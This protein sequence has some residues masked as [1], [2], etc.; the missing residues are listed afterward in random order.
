MFSTINTSS[1]HVILTV[2]RIFCR[3]C[4]FVVS[5]LCVCVHM[6][7]CARHDVCLF[8]SSVCFLSWSGH[9]APD[10]HVPGGAPVP[11]GPQD[12]SGPPRGAPGRHPQPRAG[13]DGHRR[14]VWGKPVV[15]LYI[16]LRMTQVITQASLFVFF[17]NQFS[18]NFTKSQVCD[19]ILPSC[20]S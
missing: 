7:A 5:F 12:A 9:R 8:V 1:L 6:C 4:W 15:F 11:G 3:L 20:A 18:A 10:G 19:F 14:S 16:W 13:Q 17:Q 2:S